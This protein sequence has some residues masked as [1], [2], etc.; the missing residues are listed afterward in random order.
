MIRR[1]NRWLTREKLNFFCWGLFLAQLFLFAVVESTPGVLDRLGRLRGRDFMQFYIAGRLVAGGE[2]GRLYDQNH[3]VCIQQILAEINDQCPP[4][5]SIYPPTVALLFSPLG[6]LPYG[7]AIVLWW[8]AQAACFLLAGWL[9]LRE[10]GLAPP[11]RLTAAAVLAAF[12][13]VICTFLNGQLAALLLLAFAGGLWLRRRDCC[14]QAGCVFSVLAL[15]PQ[16]AA[17]VALWLLLRR[18]WRTGGGFCL[19]LLLQAGLVAAALGP[20]VLG[21]YVRNLPVLAGIPQLYPYQGDYQHATAGILINLLGARYRT[22]STL[23]HLALVGWAGLLL[24]RVVRARLSAAPA[25]AGGEDARY[26]Y[27]L[28]ESAVVLFC[29]LLPPHLLIYDLSL[30]L[31]PVVNLWAAYLGTREREEMSVGLVVYLCATFSVVYLVIGFSLVPVVFLWGLH[32][33]ARLQFSG[34]GGFVSL[35]CPLAVAAPHA[36]PEPGAVSQP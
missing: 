35:P 19:G 12:Y 15:K 32:C 20:G 7:T 33:L 28:E 30:L 34:Q 17:G 8:L 13:P 5:C 36:Q 29:L 16:L 24:W 31:I 3:F 10:A 22:F 18:D 25:G 23:V 11:W 2:V 9:L 26:G 27:R 4:Y 6:R 1:L 21:D 14:W